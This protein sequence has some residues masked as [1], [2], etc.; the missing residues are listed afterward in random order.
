MFV[1]IPTAHPPSCVGC[2]WSVLDSKASKFRSRV[3]MLPQTVV[4][5]SGFTPPPPPP[6]ATLAPSCRFFSSS[7]GPVPELGV[8]DT[9]G[10][11]TKMAAPPSLLTGDRLKESSSSER[12]PFISGGFFDGD[13][14]AEGEDTIGGRACR[15]GGDCRDSSPSIKW[16][17]MRRRGTSRGSVPPPRSDWAVTFALAFRGGVRERCCSW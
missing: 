16:E 1:S 3:V 6:P 7:H 13:V 4:L 14:V 2:S 12:E 8:R 11:E 9:G 15:V 17:K 5:G 10:V